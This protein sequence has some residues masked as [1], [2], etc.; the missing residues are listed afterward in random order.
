[1]DAPLYTPNPPWSALLIK[2]FLP[3]TY[4]LGTAAALWDH[5]RSVVDQKVIMWRTSV[6]TKV[7]AVCSGFMSTLKVQL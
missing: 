3:P 5:M 1:M 4:S 7:T 2:L 6:S